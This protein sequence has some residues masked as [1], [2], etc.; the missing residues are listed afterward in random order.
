MNVLQQNGFLKGLTLKNITP[1]LKTIQ[2]IVKDQYGKIKGFRDKT[3]KQNFMNDFD[4]V[5]SAIMV[6]VGIRGKGITNMFDAMLS[7]SVEK[8]PGIIMRA[9]INCLNKK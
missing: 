6:D 1:D 8:G 5:L 3:K 4:N 2:E 9:F 7:N